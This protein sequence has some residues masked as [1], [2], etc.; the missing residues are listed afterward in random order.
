MFSYSVCCFFVEVAD[1]S[2][3]HNSL[4]FLYSAKGS[5]SH[6]QQTG[7]NAGLE[8]NCITLRIPPYTARLS[9]PS[10]FLYVMPLYQNNPLN[11][12]NLNSGIILEQIVNPIPYDSYAPPFDDC[13][14]RIALFS[15]MFYAI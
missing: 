2:I 8:A 12:S 3:T 7:S 1:Y 4:L 11:L 14:L 9:G 10:L 5:L 6:R 15:S 13:A